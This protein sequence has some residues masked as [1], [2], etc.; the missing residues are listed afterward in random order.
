MGSVD[1]DVRHY[2]ALAVGSYD[3]RTALDHLTKELAR[4]DDGFRSQA[5]DFLLAF[6]DARGIPILIDRLNSDYEATRLMACRDLRIYTQQP[7]PCDSALPPPE[8][9]A[10]AER[11]RSWWNTAPTFQVKGR[12]AA[13]DRLAG[14]EVLPVSFE[15]GLHVAQVGHHLETSR[16]KPAVKQSPQPPWRKSLGLRQSL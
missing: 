8:R 5:A 2:A 3:R 6:D 14:P 16:S 10:N 9:D 11:W 13:L 7:L 1:P 15:Q 12:Q 4:P